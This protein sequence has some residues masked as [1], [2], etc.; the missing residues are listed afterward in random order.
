MSIYGDAAVVMSWAIRQGDYKD[1]D[2]GGQFR[3]MDVLVKGGDNW[4]L[5]AHHGTRIVASQ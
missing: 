5:V 4:Q 3:W 1:Q 2:A